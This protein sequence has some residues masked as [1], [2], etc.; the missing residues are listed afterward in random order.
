MKTFLLLVTVSL[1]LPQ[2]NFYEQKTKKAVCKNEVFAAIKPLPKFD[3]E[4]PPDVADESDDRIL[5]TPERVKAI[6]TFMTELES[7]TE[8]TWWNSPVSD[9]N[10]CYFSR[11]AGMLTEE[12][13]EQFNGPEY[14]ASVL[15]NNHIRL[16][17]VADPCYQKSY[18]G[19][20]GFLLYRSGPKVYVTQ[21]LDGY[22]SRLGKSVFLHVFRKNADEMIEIETYN[23]AGMRPERLSYYFKLDKATHKALPTKGIKRN[24]G[25]A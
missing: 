2:A 23:I 1:L 19:A 15:G 24:R 20:N 11:H 3:Y 9:L 13:N 10:A 7:F 12:E 4:C 22:Y 17:L 6:R 25:T 21:V 8:T 5:K 14:Q 16:V 18:N